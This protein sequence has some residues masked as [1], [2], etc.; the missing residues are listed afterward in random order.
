[1]NRDSARKSRR[2]QTERADELHEELQHLEQSNSALQKEIGSLRTRLRLYTMVLQ[3]HKQDTQP[4]CCATDPKASPPSDRQSRSRSSSSP[5][6]ASTSSVSLTPGLGL[7]TADCAARP[8][9]SRSAPTEDSSA[10]LSPEAST[11]PTAVPDSAPV[12]HSLFS[13]A[14]PSFSASGLPDAGL[15]CTDGESQPGRGAGR[16]ACFSVINDFRMK[17]DSDLM[18]SSN[19]AWPR[20]AASGDTGRV[21]YGC[22][23]DEHRGLWP[24]DEHRGHCPV[25]EHRGHC[26]V[27]EHRGLWPVDEHRLHCPVDEHFRGNR[28][29]PNPPSSHLPPTPPRVDPGGRPGSAFTAKPSCNQDTVP[30]H[31]SLL[32]LLT[33]PSPLGVSDR[34][35]SSSSPL[36]SAPGDRSLSELLEDNDWILQ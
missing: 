33:V 22:P 9:L 34:P 12:L 28:D 31:A 20:R 5:P 10:S 35:L 36:D 2:K 24:V 29:N 26:P 15:L 7:Q 25:D 17:Q 23:L 13:D 19:A 16:G 1:M 18:V 11:A 14:P 6:R 32:S 27:D 8:R 3:C 4:S 30:H 21:V